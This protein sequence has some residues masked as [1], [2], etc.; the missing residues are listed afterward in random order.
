MQH[1]V[2]NLMEVDKK[3]QHFLKYLEL[4]INNCN[5]TAHDDQQL[6]LSPALF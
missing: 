6:V 1:A 4:T 5:V 3:V 2:E